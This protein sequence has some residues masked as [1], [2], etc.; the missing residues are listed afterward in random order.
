VNKS[1]IIALYDQDQR[2]NVDYPIMRRE[3]SPDLVRHFDTSNNQE[4]II[5]YNQLT[6]ADVDHIIREHLLY[7]EK[8][9]QGFEWIVYDYDQPPDL[10]ERLRSYRFEV[11][12]FIPVFIAA[13]LLG[14]GVIH[15]MSKALGGSGNF[16]M[17]LGSLGV[18]ISIS[19]LFTLIPDL[20]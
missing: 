20:I 14:A 3:V 18:G 10:K 16:D 5:T 13:W 1:Q 4:G 19:A 12:F 2:I 11:F 7:F 8:L 15:L 17:L 6:E 9:G